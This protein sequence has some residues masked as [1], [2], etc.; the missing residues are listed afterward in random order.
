MRKYW[1][2]LLLIL[3]GCTREPAVPAPEKLV[4]EGWIED[5][6][7]PVVYVTTTLRVEKDKVM[8]SDDIQSHIVKW[9]KVSISDGTEEVILTGTAS[10][11]FSP[12]YAYTTG[13]MF[14]EVGKTYT[15]KV[16]YSG[17]VA[18]ASATIPAPA[19]IEST[20]LIPKENGEYLIRASFIDNP[21]T[22]DYY[23]FFSR[24]KELDKVY[25]PTPLGTLSDAM[26]QDGKAQMDLQPGGTMFR[27]EGRSGFR[28]GEVVDVKLCTMDL[29]MY[30]YWNAFEEQFALGSVP[31]FSLDTNLPSNITG[32]LGYFAAYG[33]STATVTIP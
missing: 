6:G 5:G 10:E 2:I 31:F 21:A 4:I 28:S 14:G 30:Q 7:A 18:T 32:G 9:A 11:R 16:E 23:R 15:L 13:R 3:A 8:G 20:S 1:F 17:E 26:I 24:I 27:D 12:P 22:T 19:A 25:L 33:S 29:P